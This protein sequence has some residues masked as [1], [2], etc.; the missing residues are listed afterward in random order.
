VRGLF[1]VA[2]KETERF[3]N[4]AA[5]LVEHGSRR[6]L[7]VVGIMLALLLEI[8]DTTIVNVALPT[9][10]VAARFHRRPCSVSSQNRAQIKRYWAGGSAQIK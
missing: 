5:D 6:V 10:H 1:F 9:V 4:A 8:L 7:V 2:V 3:Q